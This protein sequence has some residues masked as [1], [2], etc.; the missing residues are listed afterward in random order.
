MLRKET[1]LLKNNKI[2]FYKRAGKRLVDLIVSLF[3]IILAS[4]VL[5]IVSIL[6]KLDSPGP[7]IYKQQRVGKNKKKF[8]IFKFRTMVYN[9]DILGP[10]S[11]ASGDKRIT[12]V[13]KKL[14]KLSLDELPQLFNV[15]FGQMSIVGP[16]PDL[17]EHL[18]LF[19]PEHI[20]LRLSVKPGITGLAQI[21][22]RSSISMNN[23]IYFDEKY[24]NSIT[25]I[26]DIKIIVCT[27][28]LVLKR[29]GVN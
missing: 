11:T 17:D 19:T 24:V 16:R 3:I 14:R 7:I 26:N 6:I 13:G 21:N 12:K 5:L 2:M 28:F 9:A 15:L 18:S 29:K 4:P 1:E 20:L 8:Y 10:G 22:G 23:R 25:F 27:I